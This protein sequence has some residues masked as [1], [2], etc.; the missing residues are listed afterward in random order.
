MA[1]K[2]PKLKSNSVKRWGVYCVHTDQYAG[3]GTPPYIMIIENTCR[4]A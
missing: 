1:K 3:H 4:R 2:V